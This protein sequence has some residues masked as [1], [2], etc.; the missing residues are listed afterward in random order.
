MGTNFIDIEFDKM[1]AGIQKGIENLR[2]IT[3]RMQGDKDD[4]FAVFDKE[5]TENELE[6]QLRGILKSWDSYN[7][8]FEESQFPDRPANMGS[9]DWNFKNTTCVPEVTSGLS[10][11]F[12]YAACK[13]EK[14]IQSVRELVNQ[15]KEYL[16]IANSLFPSETDLIL[17]SLKQSK[18]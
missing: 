1:S 3:M 6:A 9:R 7:T 15:K 8:F 18:F 12:I 2:E 13:E 5:D 10:A 17:N 16:R 11:D 14:L 4:F